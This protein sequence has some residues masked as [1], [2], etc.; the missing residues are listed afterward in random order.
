V[1]GERR[2]GA[3]AVRGGLGS[4][5]RVSPDGPL[6][7]KPRAGAGPALGESARVVGTGIS[8]RSV[9]ARQSR[10]ATRAAAP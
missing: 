9:A 2:S 4:G 1:V 7:G 8:V 3:R 5:W 10:R 6:R